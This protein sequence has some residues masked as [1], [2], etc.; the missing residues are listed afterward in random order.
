MEPSREI[1]TAAYVYR[2]KVT[3]SGHRRQSS[4]YLVARL[5]GSNVVAR[6]DALGLLPSSKNVTDALGVVGPW[7]ATPSR[8][9]V[10]A[11]VALPNAS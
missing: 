7:R 4:W 1:V 3:S 6:I 10:R 5:E 9:H 8:H 2:S 11:R